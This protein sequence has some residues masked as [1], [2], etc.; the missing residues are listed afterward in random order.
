LAPGSIGTLSEW[1]L[2]RYRLE[3]RRH[4]VARRIP[5]TLGIVVVGFS[6]IAAAGCG[7]A[8]P[9]GVVLVGPTDGDDQSTCSDAVST[10]QLA[11][12]VV[13]L[14]NAERANAGVAPLAVDSTLTA[15]A[16]AYAEAQATQG[17]TGH[18][19][20][21]GHGVG[22][23]VSSAGYN[24][25]AVGE[26]LAYGPCT[27]ESAIEGWM[28]SEGHRANILNSLFTETGVGVY[29]GGVYPTYWVQVFADPQ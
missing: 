10:T 21:A 12:Q 7:A 25:I 24:W 26:N 27:A 15:V 11:A 3:T 5:R 20:P 6:L 9:G 14:A 8:A 17:F 23:R 18:T 28:N 19:D 13:T 29:R 2:P 22:D 16:E 1:I 4:D